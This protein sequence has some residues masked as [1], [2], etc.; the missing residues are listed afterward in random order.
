MI[1]ALA[2]RRVDAA[3]AKPARFPLQNVDLVRTRVRAMLEAQGA[4]VLV[5]SAAC[6]ADLLALSEAGSLDLRRRIVLPFDRKR[7]RDTSVMDRPGDWGAEYDR[8]LDDVQAK[9]DLV[10]TE[11]T[12]DLEEY[13][14]ANLAILD[15]AASLA[16]QLHYPTCA[17]LVWDGVSRGAHDI[18]EQFGIEAR[19]RGLAV[20]EVK[21][22]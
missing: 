11:T 20:I 19:K 13:S 10:M 7:F 2:G 17:A 16:K 6:G 3:G 21:T 18:T 1:I 15:E 8:I 22:L 5:C 9:G 12:A 14:A 4:K